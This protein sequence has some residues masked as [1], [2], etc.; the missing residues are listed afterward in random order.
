[1]A[2]EEAVIT[3]YRL[4]RFGYYFYGVNAPEFGGLGNSLDQLRDW[5][6]PG[7]KPIANTCTYELDEGEENYRTFC[8]DIVKHR[9]T[10]DHLLTTWNETPSV[11]G[12]I[13]SVDGNGVV[14]NAQ[15]DMTE[16]PDGHIPGFA[17]YFW[18]IPEHNVFA[19]IRFRHRNVGVDSMILYLREFLAKFTDHVVSREDGHG[20]IEI[21]AYSHAGEDYT[22]IY[23]RVSANIFKKAGQ[24]DGIMA[25]H[26][27][28]SK[29]IRKNTLDP[30][31]H[32]HTSMWSGLV[33]ALVPDGERWP[34]KTGPLA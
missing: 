9:V 2:W 16:I 1:M 11:D 10:G 25:N 27:R 15:V 21:L 34:Q 13:A 18:F 24:V 14:G 8:Y 29:L 3:F 28:I 4:N 19:T 23:P 32:E 6:A 12:E 20:G 30:E 33:R 17:T 5:V 26:Q 22:N 31:V 7:A